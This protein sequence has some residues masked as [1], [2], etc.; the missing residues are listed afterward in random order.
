MSGRFPQCG[1]IVLRFRRASGEDYV[2]H[3]QDLTPKQVGRWQ[4]IPTGTPVTAIAQ[5]LVYGTPTYLLRQAIERGYV[6]GYLK[7][8]ERD[9]LAE[10]L[11]AR[12][13]R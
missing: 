4:E 3:Y 5:C 12:Y 8:A 1:A 10:E 11:E 9:A 6:Q 13:D 7:T 2:V